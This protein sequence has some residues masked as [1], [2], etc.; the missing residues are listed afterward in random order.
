MTVSLAGCAS[1]RFQKGQPPYDKGYT[2]LRDGYLIPEYT[3]GKENSLPG[4]ELAQ[5]RFRRRRGVVEHYYKKMGYIENRFKMTFCDPGVFFLKTVGG[6][7]R[8]P[9]IAIADY[10]YEHN[11]A[12]RERVKQIEREKDAK[13][14][15]RIKELRDK[16]S[17]YI[18]GKLGK[19]EGL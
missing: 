5:E 17:L 2:V 14:E 6:I 13:E 4:I 3:L 12:Y 9:G 15:A 16:L 10:R 19:E 18:Q 11:P 1:Y 8:L 7:F